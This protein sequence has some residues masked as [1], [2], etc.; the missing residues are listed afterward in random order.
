MDTSHMFTS[1][2]SDI[3]HMIEN[4]PDGMLICPN[5][6]H[7][8][9]DNNLPNIHNIH[10]IPDMNGV[11]PHDLNLRDYVQNHHDFNIMENNP[12]HPHLQDIDNIVLKSSAA[13]SAS[14]NIHGGGS[15]THGCISGDVNVPINDNIDIHG[16][17]GGCYWQD[18]QHNIHT[19]GGQWNGGITFKF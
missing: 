8:P 11:Q 19:G 2:P 13:P 6:T 16:G 15:D 17:G 18:P 7:L 12:S 3:Q 1:T 5:P 9:I 10:N 14:I 4:C